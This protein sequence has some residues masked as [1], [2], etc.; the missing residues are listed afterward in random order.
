[1]H[2]FALSKQKLAALD[3]PKYG[4][5]ARYFL[6]CCSGAYILA[7]RYSRRRHKGTLGVSGESGVRSDSS[8]GRYIQGCGSGFSLEKREKP[9]HGR[10]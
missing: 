6:L 7:K 5:E 10:S 9:R 2:D 4:I 8:L 1:M 3:T